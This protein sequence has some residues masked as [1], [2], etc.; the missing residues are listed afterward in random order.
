MPYRM[1]SVEEKKR[2]VEAWRRSGVA[3]TRFARDNDLPP[4]AFARWCEDYGSSSSGLST[5]LVRVEVVPEGPSAPL[6]LHLAGK[7]H[8]IEVPPGFDAAD[9]RRLVEALC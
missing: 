5:D 3:R 8:R 7:G 1:R 4:T 9:V 6:V 2:L